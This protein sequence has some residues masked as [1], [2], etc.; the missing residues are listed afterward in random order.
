[1]DIVIKIEAEEILNVKPCQAFIK[2]DLKM[3]EAQIKLLIKELETK[4][5]NKE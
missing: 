1:M 2:L 5:G 4:M 3:T